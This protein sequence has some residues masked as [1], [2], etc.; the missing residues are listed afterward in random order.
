MNKDTKERINY[1]RDYLPKMKEKLF[2]AA[3]MFIISALM[4]SSA[5]FAWITLSSSPQVMSIDTTVAAN[6]N[7]EIAL[8]KPDGSAP[9]KSAAGDSSAAEG[10]PVTRANLTWGNLINLTDPSY[11]LSNVVLRPAALRGNSGLLSSPLWGVGYGADGRADK[12]TTT[13]DFAYVYFDNDKTEFMAD[14]EAK[15]LG[16][17]AVSTVQYVDLDSG[18]VFSE[19]KKSVERATNEAKNSYAAMTSDTQS[20]GKEYIASLQGLIQAYAQSTIDGGLNDM[21]ITEYV[22]NLYRMMRDFDSGVME[23][24]GAAYLDMAHMLFY[25]KN[26]ANVPFTYTVDT[27]CSDAVSNRLPAEINIEYLQEFAKDRR[28]LKGYLAGTEESFPTFTAAQKNNNFAYHAWSA[29]NGGKVLWRDLSGAINWLVNTSTCTVDGYNMSSLKSNASKIINNKTHTAVINEGALYRAEQ[30]I[31]QKMSPVIS[32]TIDATSM[33]AM[34]GKQTLNNITVS[35]A[36]DDKVTP[37][38]IPYDL[39]ATVDKCGGAVRGNDAIAEDTY[40]MAIDFWLRTNAGSRGTEPETTTTAGVDGEGNAITTTVIKSAEIPF[41]TLEG[42]VRTEE[43]EVDVKVKDINGAEQP[44]YTLSG[45]FNGEALSVDGYMRDGKYYYIDENGE[46]VNLSQLAENAGVSITATPKKEVKTNIVGYDGVNRV[47]TDDQ[48]A[49]FEGEGTSTTQGGGSCYVFYANSE[50]DQKRFL[51]LLTAMNVVFID[52]NGKKIGSA[53]MDTENY[54]AQ[55]GKVTVPLAIEKTTDNYLGMDINAKDIYSLFELE[56]GVAKRITALVYLDGMKLSNDMVLASGDIQ[57]TLNIQFSSIGA[58]KVTTITTDAD[59]NQISSVVSYELGGKSLSI[60]NDELMDDRI[61]V[62]ADAAVKSFEYD[63]ANPAKTTVEVT[64]GGVEPSAVSASFIRAVNSTQ[65]SLQPSFALTKNGDKWTAEYTFNKPGTY[66]LRT[67]W[68]DGAEYE[69]TA[70]V[71]VEVTGMEVN[72]LV[73]DA[74]KDG[75]RSASIFTAANSFATKID[76]GF[77]DSKGVPNSVNGIFLDEDGNEVNVT[78]TVGKDGTIWSGS[79]R[80]TSSGRYT[81]KY[82]TVDGDLYE[83]PESMWITLDIQLGLKVQTWIS[84]SD[85]TLAELQKDNPNATANSFKL[86]PEKPVILEISAKVFDNNDNSIDGLTDVKILY[87]RSG[88]AMDS[89]GLDSDLKWD[90][91]RQRYVGSFLVKEAGTYR[92]TRVNVGLNSITSYTNAPYVQAM[93]PED[94]AYYNNLTEKYQFSPEKNAKMVLGL[95]YS[96]AATRVEATLTNGVV[97][98]PAGGIIGPVIENTGKDV[99]NEWTF[100]IPKNPEGLQEGQWTLRDITL[101]GVYYDG[102]YYDDENGVTIDLASESIQTKVVN[103]IHVTLNIQSAETKFTGYFMESKTVSG[104]TVTFADYEGQAIEGLNVSDVMVTYFLDS[105]NINLETYGY[106]ASG[107]EGV[108][109]S[110]AGNLKAGSDTEYALD[111]FIFRYAGAYNRCDI[112]FKCNSKPY[113]AGDEGTKPYYKIAGSPAESLPTYEIKWIAP[114]LK[115]TD[116]NPNP[117]TTIQANIKSARDW[118]FTP[119]HNHISADGFYARVTSNNKKASVCGNEYAEST[120]PK[121]TISLSDCGSNF[122][123]ASFTVANKATDGHDFSATF[124]YKPGTLS[125]T[126]QIGGGGTV[127]GTSAVGRA[128]AGY[129]QFKTLT[130]VYGGKNFEV[131]LSHPLEINGTE[132]KIPTFSY[133]VSEYAD[134]GLTVPEAAQE[135]PYYGKDDNNK[136]VHNVIKFAPIDDSHKNLTL[137]I[138]EPG[139]LD[140]TKATT[141]TT[142]STA[143]YITAT[144]KDRCGNVTSYKYIPYTVTKTVTKTPTTEK[145]YSAPSEFTGWKLMKKTHLDNVTSAYNNNVYAAGSTVSLSTNAGCDFFAVPFYKELSRT[146]IDEKVSNYVVTVTT[147]TK[148]TETTTPNANKPSGTEYASAAAINALA[149]TT[150]GWE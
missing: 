43:V 57:G 21:D 54:F 95:A 139:E 136:D 64:V 62:S 41:V 94:V 86:M 126:G 124:S 56:K 111:D 17:R 20:P 53:V 48:M 60:K 118:V 93:P 47:W 110:A 77:A 79:A 7:L 8:S 106:T 84:C 32:I 128:A 9:G 36:S 145:R 46:E 33:S 123:G 2:G 65:G 149:G 11:G 107:L 102:V 132:T 74:I 15:H 147:V 133:D 49:E 142:T 141:N 52:G 6:G 130:M 119:T 10:T 91:D 131:L 50:S 89:K 13:D 76:F 68:I 72:S 87:G 103:D 105:A 113:K 122:T 19:Y 55:N 134:K 18:N 40:A 31:G 59:G 38:R 16:V 138:V 117:S 25:Q 144:N 67:V 22:P 80:F 1:Y 45:T 3:L 51:D 70:P 98:E 88:S 112:S 69:L 125:A 104:S 34:I 100:D 30:R 108:T 83:L 115:V 143:Y 120:W 127:E 12:M 90:A 99:V 73:C 35:T 23:K 63:P 71:T 75:G 140:S 114:T 61:T 27:L 39:Q 44:A 116:T 96:S 24:C 81:M 146:L 129:Q 137:E 101:Y 150:E 37:Y 58:S 28:Q 14:L 4:M 26:G 148:G 82:Y 78:M 29:N 42:S 97:T 66:I 135:L 92:F 121:A 109:V 85:E 5:T